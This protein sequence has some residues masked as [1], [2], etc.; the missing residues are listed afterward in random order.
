[1]ADLVHDW[2]A[3][4]ITSHSNLFRAPG[5]DLGTAIDAAKPPRR[6]RELR[7]GGLSRRPPQPWKMLS[8][9]FFDFERQTRRKQ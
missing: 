1:M 2:R 7:F 6:Q 3:A 5:G 4:L 9:V 8:G